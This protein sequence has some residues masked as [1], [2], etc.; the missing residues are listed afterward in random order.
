MEQMLRLAAI[1]TLQAE[2][3]MINYAAQLRERLFPD[4]RTMEEHHK[5]RPPGEAEQ[6][7]LA[8]PKKTWETRIA[9]LF[10]A[11]ELKWTRWVENEL[12]LKPLLS[13]LES[14]FTSVFS[15]PLPGTADTPLNDVAQQRLIF[16]TPTSVIHELFLRSQLW[17]KLE[18]PSRYIGDTRR[19][20][21]G[22]MMS[23]F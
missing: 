15:E 4:L 8:G 1:G 3:A 9:L 2:R 6:A 7:Q 11:R 5:A 18:T 20:G 12:Q 10:R 19:G 22:G 21:W 23:L 13:T 14:E 16:K 17:Q